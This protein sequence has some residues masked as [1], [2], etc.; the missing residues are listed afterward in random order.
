MGPPDQP[1]YCNAVCEVLCA[2]EP[3]DLMARL[4][5]IERAA[6]R[7]RADRWGPRRIDLDLL[8]VEG[9]RCAT[10]GLSLPHPGIARRHFVLVPLAQ[11]A[12]DLNIPGVGSVAVAAENAGREGLSLWGP[13][14]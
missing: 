10:A 14:A 8:H 13:G 5:D 6:G 3:A 11:I 1:D 9:V 4:L 7:V 12:P 2:I